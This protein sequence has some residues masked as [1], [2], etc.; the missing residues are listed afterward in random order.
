MYIKKSPKHCDFD[1]DNDAQCITDNLATFVL[2]QQ[3][4]GIDVFLRHKLC[5]YHNYI[6]SFMMVTF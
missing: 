5:I 2:H 1:L 6:R 3:T 4:N